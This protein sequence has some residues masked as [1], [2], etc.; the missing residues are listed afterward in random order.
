MGSHD[1]LTEQLESK[2]A[3]IEELRVR[4]RDEAIQPST[5]E[6]QDAMASLEDQL[7]VLRQ[8]ENEL[9]DAL[10]QSDPITHANRSVSAPTIEQLRAA[11]R[12]GELL[13]VS[14]DLTT[15]VVVIA[16]SAKEQATFTLDDPDSL[17]AQLNAL[18][19]DFGGRKLGHAARRTLS[20]VLMGL[21]QQVLGPLEDLL[22][23]ASTLLWSPDPSLRAV[24]LA[25]LP[26]G[27]SMVADGVEIIGLHSLRSLLNLRDLR[28]TGTHRDVAL[29]SDPSRPSAESFPEL[30]QLG[31]Q[32][33]GL[34][35]G[36]LAQMMG[37]AGR[38]GDSRLLVLPP[39]LSAAHRRAQLAMT[40]GPSLTSLRPAKPDDRYIRVLAAELAKGGALLESIKTAQG[41]ARRTRRDPL[42]WASLVLWLD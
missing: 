13:L 24:P 8:S 34:R 40:N 3:Q 27:E 35:H 38:S 23:S 25:A 9:L 12:P 37:K 39:Q 26:L 17:A 21:S 10:F 19:R 16:L 15:Q 36:N 41:A 14:Y 2:R 30:R 32:L 6:P 11:L 28:E 20:P 1:G 42:G 18:W 29:L 33:R 22:T 31:V 7:D 5:V 4:L